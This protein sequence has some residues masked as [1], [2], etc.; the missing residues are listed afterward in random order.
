MRC[1]D[2]FDSNR[3]EDGCLTARDTLC[4]VFGEVVVDGDHDGGDGGAFEGFGFD[5]DG[6][7]A[8]GSCAVV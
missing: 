5:V 6:S 8:G 1:V 2:A 7:F 3:R 4:H